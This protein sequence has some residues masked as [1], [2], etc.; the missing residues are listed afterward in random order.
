MIKTLGKQWFEFYTSADKIS[1]HIL[2]CKSLMRKGPAQYQ[3]SKFTRKATQLTLNELMMPLTNSISCYT[4][5]YK[6][7]MHSKS[8]SKHI[9]FS[10]IKILMCQFCKLTETQVSVFPFSPLKNYFSL[11]TSI[12]VSIETVSY[13]HISLP[14]S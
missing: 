10:C 12:W 4:I 6:V 2:F 11:S 13:V 3:F 14:L 1:S 5:E 7:A 9:K 8:M